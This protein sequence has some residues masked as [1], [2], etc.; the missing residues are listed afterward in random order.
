MESNSPD[1]INPPAGTDSRYAAVHDAYRRGD[2]G[3]A[4]QLC[5][6]M[7][8]RDSRDHHA[9]F[10]RGFVAQREAHFELAAECFGA[11]AAI[12]PQ[13][14]KYHNN[15]GS[16][17]RALGRLA[18]AERAYEQALEIQPDYPLAE[19][20]RAVTWLLAGDYD[21]GWP[22]YEWRYK[23]P[24]TPPRSFSQPCWNGAPFPG[25]TLLVH[26]EQGLG[27]TIQFARFLPAARARGERVILEC[28]PPLAY[29]L[30]D[31]AGAD[32]VVPQGG[33]L[34]EFDLQLPLLSLPGALGIRLED[35][36]HA[37]PYLTIEAQAVHRWRAALRT[38]DELLIGIA[39][40]GNPKQ[41]HDRW[42]SYPLNALLPLMQ[43]PGV[44]LVSLQKGEG[45]EQLAALGAASQII[46]LGEH[47]DSAAPFADTAAIMRAVD[48][49]ITPDT[50]TA[51]LAGALCVPVWVPLAYAPDWRW[52]L[53]RTDSPWYPTMRLFR[54]RQPRTWQ[55]VFA[56]IASE[57]ASL[58]GRPR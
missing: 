14:A 26:A 45:S 3:A 38:A 7:L 56:R 11:A 30:K 47:L 25:R 5:R 48:L 50:A 29:L 12:A 54:Q 9:W 23:Q 22:A 51:H 43:I 40:Q 20:N 35:V 57:V 13:C 44:R 2:A 10:L 36:A 53:G 39:W 27:D 42:R 31:V 46:D 4:E 17:L 28:Q 33:T 55:D 49:V 32:A 15:L 6:E 16:A 34:P 21:R 24:G 41:R 8:A 37:V 1:E 19:I 18:E 58:A 52:L